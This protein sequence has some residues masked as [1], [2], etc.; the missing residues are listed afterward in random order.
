MQKLPEVEQ[1]RETM[2]VSQDWGVFR[3]LSE[4]KRVRTIADAAV[5]AFDDVEATVKDSWPDV[6]KKAYDELVAESA[7]DGSADSKRALAKAQADAS[8]VDPKV[9]TIARKVKDADDEAYECRMDAE[10]KFAEAERKLSTSMAK[11]A[12]QI[13][14]RSYDLREKAIRKSES[15]RREITK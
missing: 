6:L 2:T 4:K 5:A 13:A 8:D 9:K 11:E 14:L 3:W 10:D 1:A 7:L 12:A 15:A